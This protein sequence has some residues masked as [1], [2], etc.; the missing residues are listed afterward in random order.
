MKKAI[1]ALLTVVLSLGMATAMGTPAQA[2]SKSTAKK[3]GYTRVAVAP[4]VYELIGSAGITPAPVQG[5]K[6][7]A[8]KGTLAAKFPITGYS[9]KGLRIKHSGGLNL[10]AGASTITVSD[11][12][13]DLARLRVSGNV[14]GT[15]GN[16]GRVDLFKIR[17]SDRRDLGA[18][19]LTLTDTAAGA[20]NATFGVNAFAEDATF[21]YA[22]PKPFSRF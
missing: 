8:Y 9:L 20:L 21:G 17:K 12:N 11:F 1:L 15:V 18:V 5:A 19:K 14:S 13:I 4:A 22:T 16:V 7:G 2:A 3:V 10:S 6:A